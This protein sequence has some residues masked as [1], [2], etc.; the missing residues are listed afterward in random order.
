MPQATWIGTYTTST[1]PRFVPTSTRR[2]PR[3]D[4]VTEALGRSR[5]G[6]TTKIHIRA[7]GHGKLLTLALTPGQQHEATMFET[8]ME[9]GAVKRRRRERPRLRPKRVVGDKGYSTRRIRVYA[10]RRGIQYTIPRRSNEHRRGPFDKAMY[11]QLVERLIGRL[12]QYR[13]LA[14]R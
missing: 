2:G 4:P 5:G 8:L 6:F 1:G 7:E 12:K 11:R 10:R 13:R 9:Q 14:T 3:G